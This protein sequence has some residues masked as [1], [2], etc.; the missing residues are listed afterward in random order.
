MFLIIPTYVGVNRRSWISCAALWIISPTHVG[1][2]RSKLGPHALRAYQPH[3]CGGEPLC[4]SANIG[5]YENR[6]HVCG[7]EPKIGPELLVVKNI[8]PTYVGVNRTR[9]ESPRS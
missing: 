1:V 2:N 3:V 8:S 7:G 5:G 9:T 4:K 6:A